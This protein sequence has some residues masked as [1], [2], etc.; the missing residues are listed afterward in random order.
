MDITIS[1]LPKGIGKEYLVRWM[2]AKEA[3]MDAWVEVG[4][5]HWRKWEE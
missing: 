4:W 5:M 3:W 1:N 2:E